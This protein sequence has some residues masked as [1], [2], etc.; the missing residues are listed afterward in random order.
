M[1]EILSKRCLIFKNLPIEIEEYILFFYNEN[2][3]KLNDNL[4]NIYSTNKLVSELYRRAQLLPSET[5]ITPVTIPN[6][7]IISNSPTIPPLPYG[8]VR[9]YHRLYKMS[10]EEINET[11]LDFTKLDAHSLIN[12]SYMLNNGIEDRLI[13]IESTS[14]YDLV[15][16]IDN[17]VL[18]IMSAF[19][20]IY[21][22][23]I[24]NYWDKLNITHKLNL[25]K[26]LF[27][28]IKYD[29]I[30][31]NGVLY[32]FNKQEK[33]TMSSYRVI[34]FAFINDTDK[35]IFSDIP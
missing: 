23:L 3:K 4:Q 25:V 32:V 22:K 10:I 29:F 1:S 2:K 7:T 33:I 9:E 34:R 31:E 11:G 19:H 13:T 26:K 35:K 20:D 17:E 21:D 18:R 6:Q 27:N 24:Y 16:K 15:I 28:R 14:Y 30:H 12:L 8:Y 5:N